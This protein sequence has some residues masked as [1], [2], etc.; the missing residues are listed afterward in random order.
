MLSTAETCAIHAKALEERAFLSSAFP[1]FV[2]ALRLLWEIIKGEGG[3]VEF[4]RQVWCDQAKL[5]AKLFET[6][7]AQVQAHSQR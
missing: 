6:A 7:L 2:D 5:N 1:L 4:Y 3:R